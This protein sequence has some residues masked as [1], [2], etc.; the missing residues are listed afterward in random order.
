MNSPALSD[1]SLSDEA[2]DAYFA[3]SYVPPSMWPTP[4]PVTPEMGGSLSKSMEGVVEDSFTCLVTGEDLLATH[5]SS[6]IPPNA[7]QNRPSAPR[8]AQYLSRSALPIELI[9]FSACM[10]DNLTSRFATTWL[11]ACQDTAVNPTG[12]SHSLTRPS[13]QFPPT[14]RRTRQLIPVD[15]EL[16]VLAALSLTNSYHQDHSFSKEFWT[17]VVAE[18]KFSVR[19]LNVTISAML[20]DLNYRLQVFTAERVEEALE[21]MRR[22]GRTDVVNETPGMD[23]GLKGRRERPALKVPMAGTSIWMNGQCTPEPSP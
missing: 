15:P 5:L 11:N 23:M 18:R 7:C 17:T 3:T 9:A 19:Q 8:I 4:P 1:I 14:L 12:L 16:I 20:A 10:L 13:D 21:Y 6:L 22:V 2:L